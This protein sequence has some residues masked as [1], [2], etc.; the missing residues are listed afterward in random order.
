[1]NDDDDEL[2]LFDDNPIAHARRTDPPT[3]HAAAASLTDPRTTQRAVY[4][5]MKWS[6]P[7]SDD[8]LL[9]L[10]RTWS[11]RG[12]FPRQS[13]SGIRTRRSE[14]VAR[15]LVTDSGDAELLPSGRRAIL[16]VAK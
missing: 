13:P 5:L 12:R 7:I 8:H 10:Y 2:S 1:M 6:G 4:D 11:E 14:L 9:D 15:G 16:W 3:S